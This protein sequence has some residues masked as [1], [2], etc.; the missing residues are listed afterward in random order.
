MTD[1]KHLMQQRITTS[2][3][4]A[5]FAQNSGDRRRV[6]MSYTSVIFV[7]LGVKVDGMYLIDA[8]LLLHLIDAGLHLHLLRT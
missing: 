4:N 2:E 1:C 3:Q 7:N 5:V 6:K 8:G